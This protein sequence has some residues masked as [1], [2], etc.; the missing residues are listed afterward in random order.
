MKY[1]SGSR[2]RGGIRPPSFCY[3]VRLKAWA[4]K[5]FSE[6]RAFR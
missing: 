2:M 5:P 1:A 6:L 4:N 3:T